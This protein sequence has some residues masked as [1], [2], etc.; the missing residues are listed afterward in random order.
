M[1]VTPADF[2]ILREAC[3]ALDATGIPYVIGGGTAVALY[4]R[5]R[6]T[7]DFDIFLNRDALRKA[8]TALARA[9]FSTSDTEKRWLYKSW[10]DEVLV[11]LIVQSRGTD[12]IDDEVMAHS[13]LVE[14]YGYKI[15]MMSPEDT[16]FRKALALTEGRPDWH[17]AMSIIMR[18]GAEFDWEYLHHRA[19]MQPRRI[20]S[21][22]L[23]AQTELHA[24]PGSPNR[25]IDNYLYSGDDPGPIPEWLVFSLVRRVWLGG[26]P[27]EELPPQL[28]HRPKAA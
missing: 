19:Q 12:R 14:Q 25:F 17:D 7:K 5:N 1:E 9:G 27:L 8:M 4:G 6:R 20:L 16:V 15:P 11:D 18:Q 3:D 21:F 26:K 13:R 22:L 28:E 24:P 2:R 10:R 23:F